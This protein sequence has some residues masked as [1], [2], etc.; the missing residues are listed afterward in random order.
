MSI[1]KSKLSSVLLAPI[2][3]EKS[4]IAAE[5]SNRFVFKVQKVATKLE[6]KKAIELMFKVEVETVQVLNVKGK[7]KRFGRSLG[8]RSDWKKAYVK[9]KPGHDIDFATA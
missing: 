8:K 1:E 7:V 2:V 3:S 5:D 4:T 6:I 9:L